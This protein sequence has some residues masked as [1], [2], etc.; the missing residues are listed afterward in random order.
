MT[1]GPSF[2]QNRAGILAKADTDKDGAVSA[3]E[4]ATR[5]KTI[6]SKLDRNSDGAINRA[7]RPGLMGRGK[8]DKA[9]TALSKSADTNRDGTITW[10][11]FDDAQ[12]ERFQRLDLDRNGRLD[13]AEMTRAGA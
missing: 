3:S 12:K 10:S 5:R 6:F 13:A 7:D 8:F 4:A 2:A 1:A 9:F 11:E